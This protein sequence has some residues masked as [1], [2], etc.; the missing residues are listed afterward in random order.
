MAYDPEYHHQYYLKHKEKKRAQAKAWEDRNREKVRE[1]SRI[2]SAKK[3]AEDPIAW[4]QYQVDWELKNLEK[5]LV[6]AA[7]ARALKKGIEF[8]ITHEDISVPEFC[9]LLGVKIA[10]ARGFGHGPSD[11][12]P[13]LDRIDSAKGYVKGNVWVISALA[14]RIKT[15]ATIEQIAMVAS[16]L[17]KIL[18]GK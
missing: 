6:K 9:P 1:R 18:K 7:K 2:R 17:D 15:N 8:S 12:S 11:Y 3:R 4:R 5:V 13:T 14:N 10:S 16:N